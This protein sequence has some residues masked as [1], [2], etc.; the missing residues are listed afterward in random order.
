V[1]GPSRDWAP[2]NEF[3]DLGAFPTAGFGS[4]VRPSF[5]TLYSVGWLDLSAAPGDTA[6]A[7]TP[8]GDRDPLKY[9]AGGSPDL[10]LQPGQQYESNSLPAPLGPLGVTMRLYAPRH[11]VLDRRRHPP[12]VQKTQTG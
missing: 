5:D 3:H 6:C 10:Y 7:P 4:V 8:V 1:P 12:A 11:E 9:N 2:S